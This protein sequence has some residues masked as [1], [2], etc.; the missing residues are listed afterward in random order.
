M[1]SEDKKDKHK[2]IYE[3]AKQDSNPL[4]EYLDREEEKYANFLI[5]AGMTSE[6][7]DFR[8][9]RFIEDHQQLEYS[10]ITNIMNEVMRLSRRVDALE[11]KINEDK[12]N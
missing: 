11:K 10:R 2:D 8:M 1:K 12:D 4:R 9:R 3:K 7:A 5:S 6:L